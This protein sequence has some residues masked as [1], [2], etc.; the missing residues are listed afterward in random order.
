MKNY[1][2]VEVFFVDNRYDVMVANNVIVDANYFDN[3]RED[4]KMLYLIRL[5]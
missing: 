1:N 2:A 5:K 4:E 3:K